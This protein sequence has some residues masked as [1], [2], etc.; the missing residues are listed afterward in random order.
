MRATSNGVET[1]C[2]EESGPCVE[3]TPTTGTDASSS[4]ESGKAARSTTCATTL[5]GESTELSV[6]VLVHE[7]IRIELGRLDET[8]VKLESTSGDVTCDSGTTAAR[9]PETDV[10]SRC[11][12]E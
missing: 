3:T 6:T 12:P 7:A 1:V 4:K 8:E 10:V 2:T 5:S 9:Q 11:T